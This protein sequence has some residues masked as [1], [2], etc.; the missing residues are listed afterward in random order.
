MNFPALQPRIHTSE[1]DF[2]PLKIK[3]MFPILQRRVHG[4]KMVYLDNGATTQKPMS[5]INTLT[6]YYEKKN[7]N[8]HRGVHHLTELATASY[9][10]SRKKVQAFINAGNHQEIIFVR[11]TTEAINLVAQTFGRSALGPGDSV[12][13]TEMEHHSNIVPWQLLCEQTGANLDVVHIDDNGELN[14]AEFSEKLTPQTKLF[15]VTHISNALGSVN[16]LKEL[17]AQ[18]HEMGIPVLVDGAQATPHVKVDVQSLDCDFY[19]FSGHKMYAPTGIGVLY[20]KKE[21]L[22]AMPPYQ[23]GGDMITRVTLERSSYAKPPYKFEAGTPNIEGV[24]GLG[25]A[26]DFLTDLNMNQVQEH[27]EKLLTYA[28]ERLK[29]I[30][31]LR[32]IGTAKQ[33]AGILSFVFDE[34]HPH[35]VGTILDQQGIAVRAGHH[36]AMPVMQKFAIPATT[37]ASLGLYNTLED[38]DILIEGLIQVQEVFK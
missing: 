35:D 15:A 38:I 26:I 11:G 19:T 16:P 10:E 9:E 8:V 3:K 14:L 21:L 24:I 13:I 1:A 27:E 20:G 22:E 34:I 5:V 37:R 33:K 4:K 30:N 29:E 36:C 25:A 17:I 31:G 18:A 32:M 2:N 28:T 23:G 12:L 6:E 7:A